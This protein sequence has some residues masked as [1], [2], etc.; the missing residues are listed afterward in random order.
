MIE[1]IGIMIRKNLLE[2]SFLKQFTANRQKKRFEVRR[3]F[4]YYVKVRKRGEMA[5]RAENFEK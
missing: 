1:K 3:K 4:G 5:R 2:H